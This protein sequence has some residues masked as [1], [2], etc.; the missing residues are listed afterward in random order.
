MLFR[1][2]TTMLY[3]PF[4]ELL[5]AGHSKDAMTEALTEF[6]RA[7]AGTLGY[8]LGAH[9]EWIAEEAD[10]VNVRTHFEGLACR[11]LRNSPLP[12]PVRCSECGKRK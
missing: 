2:R 9:G 5:M 4:E 3:T 1:T 8:S 11:L 10:L 12:I 7:Y 6:E